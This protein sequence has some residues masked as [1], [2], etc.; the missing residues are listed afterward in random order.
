M[1]TKNMSKRIILRLAALL[2][3]WLGIWQDLAAAS[4]KAEL[5]PRWQAQG[6]GLALDDSPY[7]KFL[8]RYRSVGRDGVARLGYGKVSAPDKAALNAYVRAMAVSDVDRLSRVQQYA[9]WVNLYNAATI[10]L[11]LANYP[12]ASITKIK[13]G[14]FGFGPWDRKILRVKGE[15]LS[16][17]DIEHRILRPIWKDPRIHFIVN[18]ASIGCPDIG[19]TPLR[20]DT[21][22]AQLSAARDAYLAHPRAVQLTPKGL[23]VSS[24]FD[25]Y[26]SD[27]GGPDGVVRYIKAHGPPAMQAR[28]TPATKIIGDDYDW[29][30]NEAR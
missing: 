9:Y 11:I 29:S 20:A 4:P 30:L 7:A 22:E 13:D 28:I 25:W 21:L 26:G 1:E 5:W 18:C 19:A 17:N 8:A 27:F 23:K 3:L 15:Q 14:V 6:P 2:S 24:I 10:D 16:L 12:L